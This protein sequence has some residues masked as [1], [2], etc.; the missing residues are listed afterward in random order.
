MTDRVLVAISRDGLYRARA[1]TTSVLVQDAL[2]RH[3]PDALGGHALGRAL[4]S[5]A[6]FPVSFKD[7]DRISIQWSGG[8]P[9]RTLLVELRAPGRLRGYVKN[10]G[11]S[12]W[13][14]DP[15][16]RA[17]G[18]GLLPAG[19]VAVVKQAVDG[20][21]GQGQVPLHTGEVDEDL[22]AWFHASEQVPTRVRTA[23]RIDDTGQAHAAGVLLQALPGG[24]A[25]ALPDRH[26]HERMHPDDTPEQLLQLAF[27]ERAFTVLEE[28][29]LVLACPCSRERARSGVLLLGPDELADLL[30][31][32]GRA[33][34]RCEFCA[35]VFS[36]EEDELQEML[37][38]KT[39]A[40]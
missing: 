25:D 26:L 7:C 28:V 10:P 1:A 33:T 35:Q 16:G 3:K 29:P 27:G 21:W 23:V 39:G 32:E 37:A 6:V 2:L 12:L 31:T 36:F 8:G 18:R 9:L 30:R 17:I 19:T 5:G 13:G 24:D 40:A 22:E 4:T 11:A 15:R 34:V 14:G 38:M 20:T